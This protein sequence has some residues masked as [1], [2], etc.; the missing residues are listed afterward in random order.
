MRS[1]NCQNIRSE[2]EA[3]GS[4][5][6][7]SH[8]ALAHISSCAA[9]ETLSREQSRLHSIL[10]NL[11]TV[12]APGDFDFKLRA[13]LAAEKSAGGSSF[14]FLT[15]SF[16]AR[17]AA[18]A[19][20]L[21]LVVAG[22]VYLKTKPPVDNRAQGNQPTAAQKDEAVAVVPPESPKPDVARANNNDAKASD[23]MPGTST[24]KFDGKPARNRQPSGSRDIAD[25]M[26][27]V[28]NLNEQD[29]FSINASR[30]PLKV[31]VDDGRGGSRTISLPSVSFGSEGGLSQNLTPLMIA[32]KGSW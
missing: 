30:Q 23:R 10:S 12:E 15:F 29:A 28:H 18:V 6:Y 4:A 17:S 14:S 7:L 2:I 32:A 27:K 19:M 25:T 26:A 21:L 8:A 20:I 16:G 9:C 3:A 11:G 24:A 13:R 22:I 1:I 5:D 31:S